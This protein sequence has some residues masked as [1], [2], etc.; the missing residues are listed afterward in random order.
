VIPA[1][2]RKLL[3]PTFSTE[4]LP[5]SVQVVNGY[6]FSA[7]DTV[8]DGLAKYAAIYCS[9]DQWATARPELKRVVG[10]PLALL[11]ERFL[12]DRAAGT[13]GGQTLAC[14]PGPGSLTYTDTEGKLSVSGG[15]LVCAGGKATPG[16]TDPKAGGAASYTRASGLAL[17]GSLTVPSNANGQRC[18]LGWYDLG[19]VQQALAKPWDDGSKVQATFATAGDLNFGSPW[20]RGSTIDY[21]LI[22]RLA[23]SYLLAR[24][25]PGP[26]TLYWVDNAK[27]STPIYPVVANHSV[28]NLQATNIRV[29][30][31]AA[32]GPRWATDDGLATSVLT[33]PS[34]GATATMTADAVVE[35]VFNYAGVLDRIYARKSPNIA[36]SWTITVYADGSIKLHE[37][38]DS[39]P[40]ERASAAA[41]TAANGLRRIVWTME[42]NKHTVYLDNVQKFTYTDVNNLWL[43]GTGLQVTTGATATTR[44]AAY[45]RFVQ[46]PSGVA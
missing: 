35:W 6:A 31:L 16:Y 25:A 29:L 32:P 28:P 20:D 10:Q 18:V 1:G 7:A 36:N 37:W 26:Y 9:A 11:N 21:V 40:T 12:T 34:A 27:V 39:A 2:V 17:L 43:G 15:K 23:G 41:G 13:L 5:D 30:S 46:L 19:E 3:V 14:E 38:V 44:L 33:N 4:T 8:P 24:S 42:G 22:N 45:P